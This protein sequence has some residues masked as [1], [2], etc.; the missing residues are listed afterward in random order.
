M[1]IVFVKDERVDNLARLSSSKDIVYA[2]VSFVDIAGLVKGASKGEGLGNKFLSNIRETDAVVHVVRC[3]EDDNI[4]HVE[5]KINPIQDIETIYLELILADLQ[6]AENISTKLEKQFKGKKELSE[7]MALMHKILNH[8]NESKPLRSLELTKEETLL[9]KQYAF[10]T[11]KKVL[12]AANIPETDISSPE[13]N[14]YFLQVK[15]YAEKEGSGILP[16]CAKLE[17]EIAQ[18]SDDESEEFLKSLGLPESGLDRLIKAAFKLLDLIVYITTGEMETK[19]WTITKGTTAAKAAGK[20]HS[21]IEK[22]FIRAEIVSYKD[23]MKYKGRV[24]AR[25]AGLAK[26]EGRDYIIQD[27]DVVLFFHN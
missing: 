24:A 6:Q 1:G 13:N 26:S 25:E 5:G 10:L 16:I 11:S 20:I 19:A 27:G 12:Y 22:G 2:T 18:L 7:E 17:E 3:F 23:M 8:L 21:D 9:F 4:I 14:P 15:E